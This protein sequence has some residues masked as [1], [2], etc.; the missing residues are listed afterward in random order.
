[1]KTDMIDRYPKWV[2][3]IRAILLNLFSK[4][5]LPRWIVFFT[6]NLAVFLAFLL[7]Y[8]LRF[9][10]DLNSVNF[11]IAINQGFIVMLIYSILV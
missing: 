4:Y 2:L 11:N 6:D 3:Y 7:A 5:S 1:M 9:N 10:F 8:I